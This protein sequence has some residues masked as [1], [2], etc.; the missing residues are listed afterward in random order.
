M[1]MN[2]EM[3]L[4]PRIIIVDDNPRQLKNLY[5]ILRDARYDV[6]IATTGELALH[7]VNS[8]PP[9]LIMLDV[10]M[11]GLDGIEVC[12]RVKSNPKIC[13]IPVI[14]LNDFENSQD[15]PLCFQNGAAAYLT[16]PYDPQEVITCVD[17]N[18]RLADLSKRITAN[19]ALMSYG[20]A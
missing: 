6:Q 5:K 1:G 8:A 19:T 15:K 2:V 3:I 14:F 18:L 7:Y 9:D 17:T 10:R 20:R 4:N 13:S 16:K 12:S 11:P